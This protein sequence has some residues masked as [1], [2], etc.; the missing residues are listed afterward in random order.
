MAKRQKLY[1]EELKSR[2]KEIR[3]QRQQTLKELKI[4]EAYRLRM[5]KQTTEY[6]ISQKTN[7]IHFCAK[8]PFYEQA[9]K[10]PIYTNRK[11]DIRQS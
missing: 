7:I 4:S 3:L 1:I 2:I 9:R 8:Y 6:K 5:L 11:D 10:F